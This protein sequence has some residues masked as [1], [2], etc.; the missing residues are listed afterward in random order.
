MP[1]PAPEIPEAKPENKELP[2]EEEDVSPEGSIPTDPLASK[3]QEHAFQ[4]KLLTESELVLERFLKATSL[5]QRLP[6]LHLFRRQAKD[7]AETSLAKPLPKVISVNH[8]EQFS[9]PG[10]GLWSFFFVVAF[11]NSERPN[12]PRLMLVEVL[13]WGE[14]SAP[15]VN[16]D[17]FIDIYDN[18]PG[19][20]A[21]KKKG[22]SQT[23]IC[24]INPTSFCFDEGI[25]NQ[26]EKATIRFL[27]SLSTKPLLAKAYLPSKEELFQKISEHVKADKVGAVTLGLRWND[28]EDPKQPYLE[29]TEFVSQ[30]WHP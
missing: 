15:K 21:D 5:K 2:I 12:F 26:Q 9:L 13:N 24:L 18:V 16:A 8:L 11:E 4:E 6:H 30:S 20:I 28:K 27:Q 22:S 29:V 23:V 7:L 10:D 25:P 17:A 19:Q 3:T 1:E 14:R